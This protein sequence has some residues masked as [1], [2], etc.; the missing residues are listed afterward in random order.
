ML[1]ICV[2]T[3]H[4]GS[5]EAAGGGTGRDEVGG[6]AG[7]DETGCGRESDGAGWRDCSA[8]DKGL[9]NAAGVLSVVGGDESKDEEADAGVTSRFA[10]LLTGV[11]TCGAEGLG[12]SG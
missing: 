9:S 4:P 12:S 5:G 2:T 7:W 10:V 8:A 3:G 1:L 11:R 6:G